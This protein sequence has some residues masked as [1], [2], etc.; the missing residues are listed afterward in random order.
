MIDIYDMFQL[1]GGLILSVGYIPQIIKIV[2]T[3]SVKDLSLLWSL[4]VLIG[5]AFMEVYAISLFIIGTA[6]MFFITNTLSF[7][8]TAIMCIL[9]LKYREKGEKLC[10]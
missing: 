10:R 3:K 7:G 9:I 6:L 4:A 5:I 8:L 2:K 1:I